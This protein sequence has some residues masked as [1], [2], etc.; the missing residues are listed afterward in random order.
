ML[1][2]PMDEVWLEF[3]CAPGNWMANTVLNYNITTLDGIFTKYQGYFNGI[4]R[5]LGF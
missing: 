1:F 2:T 3:M 4:V 5:Y